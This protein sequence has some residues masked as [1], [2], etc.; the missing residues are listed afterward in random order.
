MNKSINGHKLP[1]YTGPFRDV[2]PDYLM[3]RDS[4]GL[5]YCHRLAQQ[6]RRM[7][8][9]FRDLG[10]EEPFITRD[11]Y[12]AYT[13]RNP[14]E[15]KGT[16]ELR[17]SAI[18]PFARYLESLGYENIY[19]GY[20]DRR[21]F[22]TNYIPYI[23]SNEEIVRMFSILNEEHISHPTDLADTFRIAMLMYYCCGF[24]RNEVINLRCRDVN[25]SYGKITICEGK[26]SISRI[27]IVSES[28]LEE[29]NAFAETWIPDGTGKDDYFLYPKKTRKA[30]EH[31]I[32][33]GLNRLLSKAGIFPRADGTRPRLHDLRHT[34][35]V[36]TLEQMQA[37][38]FDLY[39]S[40]PWLSTYLGHSRVTHTEYYLRLLEDHFEG[41]LS[42][43]EAY[44][45]N[46]YLSGEG[47]DDE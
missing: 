44:N 6:L 7:D 26:N 1:E 15:K 14:S 38:G 22:K 41:I 42:Q 19:T 21:P 12:E 47:G 9:F 46:L 37:R 40:L 33:N 3:F 29:L 30:A 5:K 39:T 34:F 28:L 27:V 23:Y 25:L 36:R 13:K 4:Q 45:P 17:R 2:I 11:A 31:C 10:V 18:R 16:V 8:D 35:C 43:V 24:R 32:Y 20:D